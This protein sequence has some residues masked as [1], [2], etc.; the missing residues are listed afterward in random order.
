VL[1][2]LSIEDRQEHFQKRAVAEGR[3]IQDIARRVLS[4]AGFTTIEEKAK[5]PSGIVEFGFRMTQKVG[6]SKRT[7]RWWVDVS[8]AFTTNKPGLQRADAVWRLLGRLHVLPAPGASTG[9]GKETAG[10]GRSDRVEDRVLIVTSNLPKRGSPADRALRA[11][12][13]GVI[14]DAIELYDP[15]GLV[16]LRQYAKSP[17]TGPEPGFW[18]AEELA[19]LS[20]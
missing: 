14:F 3:K 1:A 7:V 17:A 12:G 18:T 15:A 6:R 8:G 11:V 10:G 16:R 19:S 2:K 20:A 4:E 5:H 9:T 13:P